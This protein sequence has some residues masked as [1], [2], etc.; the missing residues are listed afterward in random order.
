MYEVAADA[1]TCDGNP[2]STA[3]VEIT[4]AS[5]NDPPTA[6]ADSFSAL[7]NETLVIN[8][9]GVLSNDSDIDGDS[10]TA[11]KVNNPTHGVVVL[12][13][14]G[15]FSY[16]PTTN[17]TGTDTFSYKA[18]D[19]QAQ[20]ATKVV[21]ITVSSIP[22]INTPTPPPP[23]PPPSPTPEPTLTPVVTPPIVDATLDPG[24]SPTEFVP[25]TPQLSG[26]ATPDAGA[27]VASL[28]PGQTAQPGNTS[29]GG[30]GSPL[31]VLL[32]LT[33]LALIVGVGV[34]MY[35]PRWMESRR[36]REG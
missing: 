18:S 8:A 11:V 36:N 3:T 9:P 25:P 12:A 16:T 10:L 31:T 34:A 15:S 35:G 32:G 17:F 4:V 26:A 1:S 20:S 14:D 27:S 13:A 6:K 28:A 7:K 22:P 24:A 5:V 23:T 29:G 2:G 19:G 21:T 30:G 33:L